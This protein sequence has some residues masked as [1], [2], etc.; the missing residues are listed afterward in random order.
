MSNPSPGPGWWLASDEKWYPPRWEYT[1]LHANGRDGL[2]EILHK[3]EELGQEGW[4]MVNFVADWQQVFT[5]ACFFKRPFVPLARQPP[6]PSAVQ[7]L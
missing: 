7:S 6:Q 1:C 3:A 2:N 4:E 5:A